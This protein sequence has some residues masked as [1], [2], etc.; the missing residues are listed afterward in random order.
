MKYKVTF[1]LDKKNLWFEQ[2]LKKY[3]FKFGKKYMFRISKNPKN[4]KKQDIVFPLS[5]TKILPKKLLI[6]SFR[7]ISKRNPIIKIV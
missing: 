7:P 4:I 1:L 6:N 5:Y 3:S 2:Y